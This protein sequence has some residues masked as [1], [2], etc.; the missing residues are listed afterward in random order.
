MGTRSDRV[1]PPE[2][3]SSPGSP[4]ISARRR[5]PVAFLCLVLVGV[6]LAQA[7]A[8]AG[9]LWPE[10]EQRLRVGLKLFP[11]VLGAVEDLK[12]DHSRDGQLHIAVG[13][14]TL[15][16]SVREVVSSIEEV[17]E[18]QGLRLKVRPVPIAD[19]LAEADASLAAVFVAS[20]GMASAQ[21]QRLSEGRGVLVFSP[22]TGDVARGAVAGV[23]VTDRILPAVNLAQAERAGLRFKAFFL[24]VAHHEE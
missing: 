18:V 8:L 21:L 16:A 3:G 10:E 14:Q 20:V 4:R 17:G 15:D 23:Y 24:R 2:S 7:A 19:L 6:A 13:Y 1:I 11:A 5:L 9:G 22:F 12:R